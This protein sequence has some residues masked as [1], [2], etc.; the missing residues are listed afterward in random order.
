MIDQSVKP[1]ITELNVSAPLSRL[2]WTARSA[3][4]GSAQAP[5]RVTTVDRVAS[6][7]HHP[8]AGDTMNEDIAK[9]I[10]TKL[11]R[12]ETGQGSMRDDLIP[13]EGK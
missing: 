9:S 6:I 7:P 1:C 10:L 2:W 8:S 4:I 12:L 5:E 13:L 11:E 3:R